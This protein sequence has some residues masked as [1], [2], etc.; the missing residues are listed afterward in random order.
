[1]PLKVTQGHRQYYPLLD[2][3]DVRSE[4]GKVSYIYFRQK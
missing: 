3:L 4:I 2:R 1:M